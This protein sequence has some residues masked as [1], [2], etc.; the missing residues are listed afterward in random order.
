[1]ATLHESLE[2]FSFARL[3]IL[4]R[5][6]IISRD[7]ATVDP[8]HALDVH[9]K[10]RRRPWRHKGNKNLRTIRKTT[11]PGDDVSTYQL[12]SPTLGFVPTHRG[13]PTLQRYVG[14]TIFVDHF[15]DLTY[16]HL[17]TSMDSTAT[18]EA[19]LAFE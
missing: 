14:A 18:V 16:V 15:S 1:M 11:A 8:P 6:G 19:K 5:A 12:I 2:H 9:G 4:A 7:L 17:M 10:A 3:K 13:K